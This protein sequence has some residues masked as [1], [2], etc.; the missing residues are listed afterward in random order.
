[1]V[2]A[3]GRRVSPGDLQAGGI[4]TVFPGVPGGV[5]AADSPTLLIRLRPGQTVKSRKGQENYGWGEYV[6]YSKICTHAGCPA[7]L[8][9]Q[10]TTRLLCPCHQSQF[11]VLKDAKPVFGPATRSLPKLPIDVEVGDDGKTYFVAKGPYNEAIGPAFW[12]RK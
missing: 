6:A 8:Y 9:E 4:A 2:Y 11:E 7:S 3:D 10:Q 12:N 1:V 5:K